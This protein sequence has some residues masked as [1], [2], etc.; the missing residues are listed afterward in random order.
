[1][2]T[3]WILLAAITTVSG[4]RNAVLHAFRSG[5][6]FEIRCT[7]VSARQDHDCYLNVTDGSSFMVIASTNGASASAGD[8]M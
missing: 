6:R 3:S 2:S 5:E 7:V 4:L 1:M 8:A